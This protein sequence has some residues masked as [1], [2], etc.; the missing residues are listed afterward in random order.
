MVWTPAPAWT[1]AGSGLRGFL[2]TSCRTRSSETFLEKHLDCLMIQQP[3][4]APENTYMYRSTSETYRRQEYI[5]GDPS[6]PY[7]C[8]AFAL[9]TTVTLQMIHYVHAST[10][11]AAEVFPRRR[12]EASHGRAVLRVPTSS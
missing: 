3:L 1:L 4:R 5:L 8:T 6:L 12:A 2:G 9:R 10:M 11:N 7:Y